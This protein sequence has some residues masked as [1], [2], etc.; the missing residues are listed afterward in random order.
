[1][2]SDRLMQQSAI[3]TRQ[4]LCRAS[5]HFNIDLP[6]RDI[7]FDLRG[8]AAG[9]VV[10]PRTGNPYIRYN[11]LLL[12]QNGEAFL[13]QTLP[14]EV[15]HLV[16]YVLHGRS[17]RPHGKEWKAVMEFFG[18]DAVRCHNFSLDNHSVK[19]LRRFTYACQCS[20]HQLTSI[21]HNRILKG[22]R[23]LCRRCGEELSA[24]HEGA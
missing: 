8:K 2:Q 11:K 23:Y 14:H 21:R 24:V 9:M 3:L 19:K 13:S 10:F 12:E 22:Q 15:A 6:C 4:L 16:A 20:R 17:I 1:M 7:R 18:A 5:E